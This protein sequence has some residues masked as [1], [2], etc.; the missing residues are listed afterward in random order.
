MS[1]ADRENDVLKSLGEL[2]GILTAESTLAGGLKKITQLAAE[3][4]P[5]A[6]HVGISLLE[7]GPVETMGS[8]DRIARTVD[9]IQHEAGEGPCLE[10]IE[11]DDIF[12]VD[13]LER[14][15]RWK[16]FAAEVRAQTP[17]RSILAIV[18]CLGNSSIGA[19]N[20]YGDKV[21]AFTN[22]DHGIAA[23]FASQ[24]AV[25]LAATKRREDDAV[26]IQ[27]LR[28]AL[29]S[30]DVIGQAKGILMARE[31]CT[32]EEAFAMLSAASQ[33]LNVKLREIAQLVIDDIES[34]AGSR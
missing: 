14:D 6:D 17:V 18:L 28:Q 25:V 3:L 8:S 2:G 24:A 12:R 34:E 30:R 32:D 21:K 10:S 33:K 26:K 31:S 29:S 16:S 13:D 4:V 9:E 23:L 15:E 20:L 19:L 7:G 22:D 5:G 11:Q 27:N 1:L